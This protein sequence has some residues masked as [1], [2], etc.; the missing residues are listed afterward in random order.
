MADHGDRVRTLSVRVGDTAVRV[1]KLRAG[2]SYRFS[3]VVRNAV[4]PSPESR[5]SKSVRPRAAR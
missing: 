2:V 1:H 3:V 5:L 4:G